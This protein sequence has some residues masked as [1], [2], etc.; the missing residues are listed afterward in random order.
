M[1][2]SIGYYICIRVDAS[3]IDH[4]AVS[5]ELVF[6]KSINHREGIPGDLHAVT[7][8]YFSH[9]VLW[10]LRKDNADLGENGI[11]FLIVVEGFQLIC[12]HAI[13]QV[14]IRIAGLSGLNQQS[15]VS[16]Q[17]ITI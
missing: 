1:I 9:Y 14:M 8:D 15:L 16:I 12:I 17:S 13:G 2:Q 6:L 7:I 4:G 5:P 3:L 11:G 10:A